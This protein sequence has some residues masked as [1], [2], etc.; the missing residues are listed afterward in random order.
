VNRAAQGVVLLLVG[1]AVLRA[2][3]TDMYLRYVREGLRPF[4]IVAGVGLVAVAIMTLV[5]E[6]VRREADVP[7]PDPGG[8]EDHEDHAGEHK[9]PRVSWLMVLPALA[10]LLVAPPALGSDAAS[11]NGTALGTAATSDFPPLPKGDPAKIAV[12]DYASR[13]VFEGGKSIGTR[14][15][16]LTGFVVVGKDGQR[17]LARMILTCC[18]ADAR[19][20]KVALGGD[21]PQFGKDTWIRVVGRYSKQMLKDEVNHERIPFVTVESAEKITPPKNRYE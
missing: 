1:G 6:L 9:E 20:I 16:E 8:A 5:P 15:V 10:L 12:L 13:A 14:R 2:S 4:L 7:D 11:R 21:V 18:A 19:P 3:L 17:Y